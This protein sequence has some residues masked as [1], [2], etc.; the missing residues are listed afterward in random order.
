MFNKFYNS[1]KKPIITAIEKRTD[2]LLDIIDRQNLEIINIKN[3][4]KQ[5]TNEKINVV[6]ICSEP[7]TWGSLKTVFESCNSDDKFNATIIAIPIK[8]RSLKTENYEKNTAFEYFSALYHEN[9]ITG[10]NE[11]EK[12]WLDIQGLNPDYIFYQSPYNTEKPKGYKSSQTSVYSSICYINYGASIVGKHI[13]EICHPQDFMK[14][15]RIFFTEN[16]YDDKMVKEHLKRF[17]YDSNKIYLTGFPRY[18]NLKFYKY[19]ESPL[20]KFSREQKKFRTIWTPRW[21]S[22]EGRFLEYKDLF[23]Q[24]ISENNDFDFI[25]RPHPLTFTNLAL[26]GELSSE[27][28]QEY[29]KQFKKNTNAVIDSE[30]EYLK[31]FYSSDVLVTDISSIIGE[32]FLT[33]KPII[34]CHKADFF[35]DFSRKLAEGFYWAYNWNDVTK[36]LYMLKSG[37]DPLKEKRGQLIKTEFYLP[38]EGAGYKIKEI[39][40]KD[41]YEAGNNLRYI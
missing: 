27:K 4:L 31:Q 38:D 37:N 12:K 8:K 29:I 25:F 15:V 21:N 28:G 20:W 18:D 40:K 11:I 32:Y 14:N 10:Y 36:Y 9:T 34:Y 35:N 23:L 19:S 3:K 33:G 5:F 6:F 2:N 41:F 1:I 26:T 22:K 13:F 39:I 7:E 24:F 17:E 30:K 16:T